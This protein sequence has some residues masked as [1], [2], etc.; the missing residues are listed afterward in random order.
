MVLKSTDYCDILKEARIHSEDIMP[1]IELIKVKELDREEI[2]FVYYKENKDGKINLVPRPLD[3]EPNV[4]LK[5]LELAFE[6]EIFDDQFKGALKN[7][8]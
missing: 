8:L 3:L 6:R 5:L 1:A 7:F 4:L 2:R